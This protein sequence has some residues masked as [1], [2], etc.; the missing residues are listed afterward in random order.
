MEVLTVLEVRIEIKE[1]TVGAKDRWK[2]S[3]RERSGM[4][5]IKMQTTLPVGG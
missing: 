5:S 1:S 2:H 3:G 4:G